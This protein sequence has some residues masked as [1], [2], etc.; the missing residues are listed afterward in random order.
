[1]KT[2]YKYIYFEQAMF[3]EGTEGWVCY[4]KKTD[5]LLGRVEFYKPW[6]Q[7]IIEFEKG[8]SIIFNNTCLRDIAH[9]LDQLNEKSK[10]R[11]SKGPN[12]ERSRIDG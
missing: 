5:D 2:K 4:N 7:W 10:T 11:K 8:G 1:M 6:K 12:S 3:E 9:F